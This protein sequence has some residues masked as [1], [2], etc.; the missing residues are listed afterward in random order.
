MGHFFSKLQIFNLFWGGLWTS[1]VFQNAKSHLTR[2]LI[3]QASQNSFV[4]SPVRISGLFIPEILFHAMSVLVLLLQ[5]SSVGAEAEQTD[6]D[7]ILQWET[8]GHGA[9][10]ADSPE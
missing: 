6:A 10:P 4:I 1:P 2:I 3:L 5:N 9:G 7:T 8:G